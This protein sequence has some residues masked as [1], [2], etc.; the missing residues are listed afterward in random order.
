MSVATHP[1]TKALAVELAKR[2]DPGVFALLADPP[3]FV[4]RAII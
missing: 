3:I 4:T 1:I 2:I